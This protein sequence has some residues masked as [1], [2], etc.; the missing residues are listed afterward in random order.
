MTAFDDWYTDDIEDWP[1]LS[2]ANEIAER[3][4]NAGKELGERKGMERAADMVAHLSHESVKLGF[5]GFA[6]RIKQIEEAIR[7]DC[8]PKD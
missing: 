2:D 7:N 8:K 5:E 4:F 6:N 1:S 3:A